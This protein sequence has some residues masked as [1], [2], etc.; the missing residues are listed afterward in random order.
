MKI[1]QKIW[2]NIDN[3]D[4]YLFSLKNQN[5]TEVKITNYGAT[6]VSVL[7]PDNQ[8]NIADVIVG[9]NSLEG[10]LEKDQPY[11]GAVIGRY[12]NRIA[13]GQCTIDGTTYDLAVNNGS[14]HLHGGIKGFDKKVWDSETIQYKGRPALSFSMLSPDGEENYP[15]NLKVNVVYSLSEGGEL[16]IDYKAKTDKTTIVNLTNH[17][18]FNLKGEGSTLSQEMLINAKEFTPINKD[19]VPTGEI[20]NVE[21]SPMDFRSSKPIGQDIKSSYEQLLFAKGY[22]HN[23]IIDKPLNKLGFAA[24]VVDTE[25][26]RTLEMY[27][28]EPG[29]QFYSANWI[30]G[31]EGKNGKLENQGAFCLEAQKYPDTPNKENFPSALV[32]PEKDYVQTTIYKFDVF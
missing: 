29:V 3:K 18:Y 11:F 12:A 4:V 25:S 14:N 22:D 28:T 15:G 17:A 27:T 7:T 10:F 24:K 31:V 2:G 32:T 16:R 13:N 9:K 8:G 5:G 26:G 6:L 1:E 20:W 23:Y 30:E 19:S 21:N